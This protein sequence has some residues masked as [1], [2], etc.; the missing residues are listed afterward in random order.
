MVKGKSKVPEANPNSFSF[1]NNRVTLNLNENPELKQKGSAVK[2]SIDNNSKEP[3]KILVVNS[4]SG[5]IAVADKCTHGGRELNFLFTEK[6]LQCS[7][8]GKSEFTLQGKVL[9]GPAKDDLTIFT[10]EQKNNELLIFV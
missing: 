4:E 8:F 6:K 5:Y 9:S 3:I 1:N 7:S 10:I 2:F